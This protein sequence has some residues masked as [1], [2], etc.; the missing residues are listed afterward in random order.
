MKRTTAIVLAGSLVALLAVSVPL[1][2]AQAWN[3]KRYNF[4]VEQEGNVFVENRSN[5]DEPEQQAQIYING[6]LIATL[7]V[8]AMP[9]HTD[10]TFIGHVDVPSGF[11]WEVVGTKDCRD[12]GEYESPTPTPTTVTLT[13]TSTD[14]P[15]YQLNLSH[16]GCTGSLV[17]VHFVLLNVSD[18][19]TPGTLMYTY[20]TIEPGNHTGN[21]W[22]YFDWL[23]NGYYNITEASVEVNGETVSSLHN[24]GEYAGDYQCA[25]TPTNTPVTP[26][27]T[28][29]D[30]TATPTE[31][32]TPTETPE[33]PTTTPVTL[34]A[35]PVTVT[36]TAIPVTPTSTATPKTPTATNTPVTPTA[37]PKDPTATPTEGLTPTV[38]ATLPDVPKTGGGWNDFFVAVGVFLGSAAFVIFGIARGG[39][40]K[41]KKQ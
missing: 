10:W 7:E 9:K 2:T 4:R 24:P 11:T 21:V 1:Q 15:N 23:P 36:P 28:P 40:R 32:L 20:G 31:G 37:T 8:L 27:A 13:P 29:K 6:E 12:R 22:H 14:V 19:I 25:P 16:V 38:T 17:E 39:M 5:S 18:G 33:T 41:R 34:T 26:T 35:T 3:C 30:P